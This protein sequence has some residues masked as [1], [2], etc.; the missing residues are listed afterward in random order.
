[1]PKEDLGEVMRTSIN[2]KDE[3]EGNEESQKKPMLL[4]K[5]VDKNIYPC[6]HQLVIIELARIYYLSIIY[7]ISTFLLMNI[8]KIWVC[9]CVFIF[10]LL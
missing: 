6:V 3:P 5:P 8:L 7:R 4:A 9:V 10:L 2:G 1:M